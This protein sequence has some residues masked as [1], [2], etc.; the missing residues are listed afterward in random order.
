MVLPGGGKGLRA[1]TTNAVA[2]Q[3]AQSLSAPRQARN[4]CSL[5]SVHDRRDLL[6]TEALDIGVVDDVAELLWH[7]P[8][9]SRTDYQ[10]EHAEHAA[11]GHMHGPANTLAMMLGVGPFGN[12]EMGGMFTL[13]K[14]RDDLAPGDFRDPGWYRNPPGTV[15]RRVSSDPD[16]GAPV[17]APAL[18][19]ATQPGSPAPPVDHSKMHHTG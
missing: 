8:K 6:V 15:A 7:R 17:R 2:K 14:V 10:A 3:P 1:D 19:P 12:L 4:H 16:F 18:A 9:K 5:R 11:M 13:I